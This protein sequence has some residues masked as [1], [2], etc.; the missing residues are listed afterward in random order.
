MLPS[1]PLVQ[2]L[3]A[4]VGSESLSL[5]DYT[6]AERGPLHLHALLDDVV[7]DC[8]DGLQR[9]VLEHRTVAWADRRT[10]DNRLRLCMH[11]RGKKGGRGTHGRQESWGGGGHMARVLGRPAFARRAEVHPV[12]E[13]LSLSSVWVRNMRACVQACW[14]VFTH[15]SRIAGRQAGRRPGRL[16][17]IQASGL[18]GRQAGRRAGG[19]VPG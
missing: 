5:F 15:I 18:A 16:A 9:H 4:P 7:R 11:T 3:Q 6:H 17:G 13:M 2:E 10:L 8:R 14:H 12:A 19:R 1:W